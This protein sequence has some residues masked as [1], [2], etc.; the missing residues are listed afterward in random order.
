MWNMAR[1][2]RDC[3]WLNCFI[4]GPT[5]GTWQFNR[6]FILVEDGWGLSESSNCNSYMYMHCF[7]WFLFLCG[8]V[9]VVAVIVLFCCLFP[10]LP[11]FYGFLSQ[12]ILFSWKRLLWLITFSS[13]K[14]HV[15]FIE[16]HWSLLKVLFP[17]CEKFLQCENNLKVV[18]TS[19]DFINILWILVSVTS[20]TWVEVFLFLY[21]LYIY[22]H[23]VLSRLDDLKQSYI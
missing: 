18:P 7:F 6:V 3:A 12:W 1:M 10:L 11:L 21:Y 4:G 13:I 2:K 16:Y 20:L 15:L 14:Y 23:K 8:F 9:F 22:F 5:I 17:Q 19:C